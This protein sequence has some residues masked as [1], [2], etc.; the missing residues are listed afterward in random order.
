M[1][2]HLSIAKT[3][4]HVE[5]PRNRNVEKSVELPVDTPIAKTERLV[6]APP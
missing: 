3:E 6:Q 4:K 1:A 5:H 2:M